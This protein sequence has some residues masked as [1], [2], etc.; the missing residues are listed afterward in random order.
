MTVHHDHS[1]QKVPQ[2]SALPLVLHLSENSHRPLASIGNGQD[3]NN[4][5]GQDHRAIKTTG[6]E[7]LGSPPSTARNARF[8]I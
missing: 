3:M 8:R 7:S 2:T 5:V 1:M 4:I 6:I